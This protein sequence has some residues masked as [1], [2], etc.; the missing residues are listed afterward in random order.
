MS[1]E[2]IQWV[3][4]LALPYFPDDYRRASLER[5]ATSYVRGRSVL[6][7]RCLHGALAVQLARAGHAVTAL[8]GFRE[9]AQLANARAAAEGLRPLAK[10]WD[11]TNLPARVPR[12]RFDTVLALDLLIHVPDDQQAV[13]EL[14]AVLQPGGRLILTVP[15]FPWL[16][17]PRDR[18]RGHLR[19]YSRA[20]LVRLLTAAGFRVDLVRYWNFASLPL[21]VLIEKVLRWRMPDAVRYVRRRP[22]PSRLNRWLTWWFMRVENRLRFPLGLTFF[23]VAHKPRAKSRRP[24]SGT[25]FPTRNRLGALAVGVQGS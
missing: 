25:R 16:Q 7:A 18:Y 2:T 22:G 10:V 1:R 3:E 9:A 19:R 5:L 14:A 13:Q 11:F 6:D 20:Q 12:A 8:D 17:G 21:Y 4:P 24:R 15:A 23:V